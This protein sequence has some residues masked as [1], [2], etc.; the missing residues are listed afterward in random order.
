MF[1]S[2]FT[3][4]VL[5][6]SAKRAVSQSDKR[7]GIYFNIGDTSISN[8][9]ALGHD[10]TVT[11]ANGFPI[12]LNSSGIFLY[13]TYHGDIVQR[14]IWAIAIGG[15]PLLGIIEVMACDCESEAML[16][17]ALGHRAGDKEWHQNMAMQAQ[18]NHYK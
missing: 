3:G 6:T 5:S 18:I 2:R 7:Y 16:R 14:E 11:A 13:V 9:V 15:T 17:D 10:S 12:T 1:S 8:P 4:M